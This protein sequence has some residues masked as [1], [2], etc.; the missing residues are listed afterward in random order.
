MDLSRAVRQTVRNLSDHHGY[1]AATV[2]T[3]ALV[4]AAN[5]AVFSAVHGVLLKPA[6]TRQPDRLVI[7]W[8]RDASRS[9][10]VELSYRNF[11]DWVAHSRSFSQAAAIGSSTWPAILDRR[12]ESVRL[13]SAGV[14]ASFFET[15]GVAPALGR[16]FRPEDD[17]PNAP[18]VAI[19]SHATWVARFG[20]DSR[21]IGTAIQ[22][23]EPH[24][25]IGVMPEE[26]DFPHRTDVWLPVVPIL[27]NA[28]KGSVESPLEAVGVLFVVGRLREGVTPDMASDDLNRLSRQ[29]QQ[30][31]GAQRFGTDVVVTPFLDYLI[32]P[33]RPALWAL[34]AAVGV[35]LLIGCAN[36]S[37]LM[38]TRLAVR[39]REDAIRLAL[40][41]T[42]MHL[43]RHWVLEALILSLAGGCLGL[44]STR[45]MLRGIVALSP[46]DVP[47]LADIS[48]NLAV[49]GF[50]F[51]AVLATALLCGAQPVRHAG[52]LSVVE[53]LNEAARVTSGKRSH[54]ARSLLVV[55]QIGLTVVLLVAA[56]LV[57]RSFIKLRSIDLGF[58]PSNVL[59]MNVGPRGVTPS[60]NEWMR[61]LLARVAG[62]PDVEAAGA[63][64]LR[65][66]ALGPIGAESWVILEDQPDTQQIR[67]LNPTVSYQVA[68]PGY[69]TTMRIQLRRGRLFDDRDTMA[70]PRVAIVSER[71]ARG[72][73]PGDDPIGRRILMPSH[74]AE[75]G[76]SVWRT[77][78][79]VVGD[80]RYR[81]LDDVRLD[82]YDPA[83]QTTTP[84]G[85]LVVRTSGDPLAVAAAVQSEARRLDP[86]VVI[87]RLT[88]MDAIVSRAVGPWR[89]SMW[90]FT[91]FAL[92]AFVLATVGLFSL[93]TLDVAQRRHEFAVRLA[94]GARRADLRRAVLVSAW[95]HALPGVTCGVLVALLASRALRHI[96]FQVEPGDLTTYCTVIGLVVAVVTGASLLPARRA[97]AIDPLALLRRE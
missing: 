51:L 33:V 84:A 24:T 71:A 48:I 6:P 97:A 56:G 88:T 93:V 38:L 15:L 89:F 28:G 18:R 94:L 57:V 67:S 46:D 91:L 79:G 53:A 90:L 20:A 59:T 64:F 52:T 11:E 5:S 7:C 29:L 96:L 76:P 1:T 72:L 19:L 2:V 21:V 32:G 73:W 78:V 92:L 40:G 3:L 34:F 80:V 41:A 4:I 39:R 37:G 50:T 65:P 23:G 83:L 82:V 49:A 9:P 8:E 70:S 30:T 14:S 66:L 26:F 62:L 63:V 36:V 69:F 87:D 75:S 12:G 27:A 17:L 85:D 42:R 58:V 45:W 31:G 13:A 60:A 86:R 54:R 22:L 68:T 81:G 95:W 74:S 61:D 77:V 47:R 44:V 35:L 16:V 43:A 25:V 55:L 10:V